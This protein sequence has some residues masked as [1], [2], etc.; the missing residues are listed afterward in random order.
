MGLDVNKLK[1]EL[2]CFTGGAYKY[3]DKA[4]KWA[5]SICANWI[6]EVYETHPENKPVYLNLKQL[7]P[8]RFRLKCSI[9]NKKEGACVQC[10]YGRC[11][12]STHSWCALRN[13]AAGYTKRIVRDGEGGTLWEIFCK[14]HAA[15]VSDPVKP[16]NKNKGNSA[17]GPSKAIEESSFFAPSE[18]ISSSSTSIVKKKKEKEDFDDVDL[19]SKN[20]LPALH[21]DDSKSDSE[22]ESDREESQTNFP[23]L[24]LI[25]WPGISEGDGMDTEHFWNVM[26]SYFPEDHS[27]KVR[28]TSFYDISC[29]TNHI[30]TYYI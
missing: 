10:S 16:K 7:D 13:T 11:T 17:P 21:L 5:H 8:K 19:T 28:E 23:I 6:P 27:E 18:P 4:G 25:E 26:L 3:T 2:C 12:T 15:A 30:D 14:T 9:C 29:C 20:L 1:C 24:N 22:E